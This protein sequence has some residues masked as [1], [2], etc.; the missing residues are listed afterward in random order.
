[1][2]EPDLPEAARTPHWYY[3]CGVDVD[4]ADAPPRWPCSATRSPTGGARRPTATAA[5]RTTSPAACR[6]ATGADVGVL[7]QGL[8]GNRVLNDGLGPNALA[9]LDRDVL[10]QPG[11]RWLIVLEGI[12]DLGTRSATA[13]DLIA[14]YEQI[15]LRATRGASRS[16]GRPSCRARARP[17][18]TRGWRLRARR[19]TRWI[20]RV[21][22]L[23]RGHRLRRCDPGSRKPRASRPRSM[24]A[25]TCTRAPKGTRSW[26]GRST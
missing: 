19:S 8:G 6:R 14:A 17:T 11:V 25:T 20:R 21:G 5:G 2:T 12:N 26:P 4:A 24:A 15:I 10:A 22:P 18:S 3:L 9:R 16:T 1:M 7:N 13:R 23:R